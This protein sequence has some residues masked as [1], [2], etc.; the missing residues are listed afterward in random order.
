MKKGLIVSTFL[1]FL[2]GLSACGKTQVPPMPSIIDELKQAFPR[3]DNYYQ[4]FVRSFAD[5]DGDGI[6]DF[7]GI[8]ENLPYLVELGVE[9]LWLMPIHPS[10]SYHGYD[11]LDY[12]GVHEDFGTLE[13]FERLLEEADKVG[14]KIIIDYVLNHTGSQ[15]PWFIQSRDN[16]P[17][18]RS[19]YTW[20]NSSDPRYS[21]TGSWGQ[22][23]WHGSGPYYAGYFSPSMPD[24]NFNNQDVREEILNIAK[25][26]IDL[27]V[28]GFRL[29]AAAHIYGQ[30]ETVVGTPVLDS[31]L[32][33]LM[34]FRDQLRQYYPDVYIVG[35]VWED[36]SYYSMFYRSMDSAFNFAL[37]DMIMTSASGA[38]YFNY[39]TRLASQYSSFTS[40]LLEPTEIMIDA[41]FLRNHDQDRP[42]STLNGDIN[43]LRLAAE[44]LLVLPGNPFVYYG[45]ELGMKGIKT[46]GTN[47]IW[48]ETRRLPFVWGDDRQ[49]NWC[50]QCV[51]YNATLPT[52]QDQVNDPNALYH[53]YKELL[54]LRKETPALK[55]GNFE[56]YVFD[57]NRIQGFFRTLEYQNYS[58]TVMV[59][60]NFDSSAYVFTDFAFD[61]VL[62]YTKG[63]A[64]YDGTIAPLST[65]IFEV[66]A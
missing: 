11:V 10:M 9:G 51:D 38:S 35:E 53:V 5:S 15:H 56:P 1:I 37:A 3:H 21:L 12:Y 2:M 64:Q 42:A 43:K 25:Y 41:P 13:D 50:T 62:Y 31:N 49:T 23:I 48:D 4:I 26:W 47:G 60:H 14:I 8:T 19:W 54:N 22:N 46:E 58:Q 52:L 65:I 30:G 6:G 24:L 36:L 20:I 55:Y 57:L 39:T 59:V 40:N 27:G 33:Y 34:V 17:K 66:H 32:D 18:Y 7:N 45:E 16:D 63:I 44:M 29:D 28:H 61:D